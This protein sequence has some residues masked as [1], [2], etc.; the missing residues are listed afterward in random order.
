HAGGADAAI[1]LRR[2]GHLR[3]VSHP[4]ARAAAGARAGRLPGR[5]LRARAVAGLTPSAFCGRRR[6][7]LVST[8]IQKGAC[9]MPS[10]LSRSARSYG[11]ALLCC[12]AVGLAHAAPVA[13]VHDAAQAQRQPMLDTMRDLVGIESG[14]KDLEG[15]QQLAALVAERLKALDGKVEIITPADITR[16]ADTPEQ[17]GPMVHAEFQGT[18]SKKIML[19]A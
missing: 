11:L 3:H 17:V 13:A 15:L 14:S 16:L 2:T 18:G 7:A 19:I 5:P 6:T 1:P 9:A 4:A 8:A 10:S 12:A